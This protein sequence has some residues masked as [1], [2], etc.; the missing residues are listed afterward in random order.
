MTVK[1]RIMALQLLTR[2]ER[3]PDFASK[4]GIRVNI[5]HVRSDDG[6]PTKAPAHQQSS[7]LKERSC[8]IYEIV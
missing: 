4:T 2:L 5:V 7:C 1:S 3:N 8:A 6:K